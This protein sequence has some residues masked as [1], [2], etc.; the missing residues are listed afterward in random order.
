MQSTSSSRGRARR[1]ASRAASRARSSSGRSARRCVNFRSES[2]DCRVP[3]SCPSPRISRSFSA[4]SKPSVVETRASSR[5]FAESV[6]CSRGREI[7]QAVRLLGAAADAA[8]QL[9]Q[10]REAEAVGLLHDHDR[11]VRDVDADLD[12]RRR[13]EHVELARLEL[14]HQLAP[15]RRP[16]P[17]V[18]Q[19]DAVAL[20]LAA[21]E[22]L[23]LY[24]RRRARQTSPTPRSAGTRRTPAARR[25]GAGA[26]A[27][28]PPT[29]A[30][31]SPSA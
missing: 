25:R 1:R 10:R 22:P 29:I 9:V 2:P 15:L 26:S 27:C 30:P 11:R 13:D 16:Q 12:H 7:E 5:S 28:T 20:Q 4:S 17:A 19:A 14:R 3:S 23:G 18:Q 24:L 31:R 21:A 6:S 8:A